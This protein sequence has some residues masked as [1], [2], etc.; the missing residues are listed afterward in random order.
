[1]RIIFALFISSLTPAAGVCGTIDSY[2]HAVGDSIEVV[3]TIT[4]GIDFDGYSL[5]ILA[6]LV[7]S[8]EP[9]ANVTP[10]PRPIAPLT[11]TQIVRVRIMPPDAE[12]Y[13]F[14]TSQLVDAQGNLSVP[15][16]SWCSQA[17]SYAAIGDA[18]AVRGRLMFGM[19][20][21]PWIEACAGLNWAPGSAC[22][23]FSGALAGWERFVGTDEVVNIYAS[24][25]YGL[26]TLCTMPGTPTMAVT[27]VELETDPA[28]CG[29]V[30][31]EI[32]NWGT[33]KSTFR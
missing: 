19:P 10:E 4:Q 30:A 26:S 28:G 5:M 6:Q 13:H 32:V 16:R 14:Y 29:A 23:D 8:S 31:N 21:C 2:A 12:R 27:R 17:G 18:I 33:I 22:A 24:D 3:S 1:M 25:V 7:G 11:G 9:P 20:D 15:P